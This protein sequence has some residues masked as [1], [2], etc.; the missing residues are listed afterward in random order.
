M[1][2]SIMI[3][4][5]YISNTHTHIYVVAIAGTRAGSIENLLKRTWVKILLKGKK[6]KTCWKE[7]EW[8]KSTDDGLEVVTLGAW[9]SCDLCIRCGKKEW[10]PPLE[11]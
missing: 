5:E 3:I 1:S 2:L 4:I 6:Q 7:H 11:P 10:E 9:R 8:S